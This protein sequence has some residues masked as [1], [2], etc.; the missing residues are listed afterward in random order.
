MKNNTEQPLWTIEQ[1]LEF[2][3]DLEQKLSQHSLHVGLAGSCFYTG[4][5]YKD[6][7]FIVYP[8]ST[9]TNDEVFI[10]LKLYFPDMTV[11]GNPAYERVVYTV[12]S[13]EGKRVD[14]MVLR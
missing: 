7:D 13:I 5:S 12:Q 14:I 11:Y 8:H 6:A 1:A 2:G 4:A 10:I 3:R 9:A